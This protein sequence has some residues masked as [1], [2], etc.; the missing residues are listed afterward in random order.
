M[1]IL[2]NEFEKMGENI[3]KSIQTMDNY[4]IKKQFNCYM[5]LGFKEHR[6]ANV[7]L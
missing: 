5:I 6:R 1:K 2:K 4:I 3:N 7:L